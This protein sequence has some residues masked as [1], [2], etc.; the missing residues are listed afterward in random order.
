MWKY[1]H[2][3]AHLLITRELLSAKNNETS[4]CIFAV[5]DKFCYTLWKCNFVHVVHVLWWSF[6]VSL[7]FI[8]MSLLRRWISAAICCH[9][10]DC[11]LCVC[12]CKY[13]S[14]PLWLTPNSIT[15]LVFGC[16]CHKWNRLM[17]RQCTIILS[18]CFFGFFP[19]F[20]FYHFV[21]KTEHN[22]SNYVLLF[23][24]LSV[25]SFSCFSILRLIFFSVSNIA[26][27]YWHTILD[28]CHS[29]FSVDTNFLALLRDFN[30]KCTFISFR[31]S[32]V[33]F[34]VLQ[35]FRHAVVFFLSLCLVFRS[36]Q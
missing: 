22:F 13:Q 8:W 1:A 9:H 31:L 11:L 28:V 5:G 3:N 18:W 25:S 19:F 16:N 29:I 36:H 33:F 26:G 30:T 32:F 2:K 4:K 21:D 7:F 24:I 20:T 10:E 12:V 23:C 15:Q 35:C 14:V 27:W 17:K 6:S 34:R